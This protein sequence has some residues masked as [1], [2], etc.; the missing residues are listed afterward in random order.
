M[1]CREKK[2]WSSILALK[3][4]NKVGSH[5]QICKSGEKDEQPNS[6][7]F[8]AFEDTLNSQREESCD[9]HRTVRLN[10]TGC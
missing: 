3:V 6:G 5:A 4:V 1:Y 7:L 9:S 2:S 8:E 10:F